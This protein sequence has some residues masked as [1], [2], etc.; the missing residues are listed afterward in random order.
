ML[1][2]GPHDVR[3]HGLLEDP[4][5]VGDC[6]REAFLEG[7]LWFPVQKALSLCDIGLALLRIVVW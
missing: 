3:K 4:T 1:L 6:F 7:H 5:E 2:I